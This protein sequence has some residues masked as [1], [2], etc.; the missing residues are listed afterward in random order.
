MLYYQNS[1]RGINNN[2]ILRQV[3]IKEDCSKHIKIYLLETEQLTIKNLTE[4]A[5]ID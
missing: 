3:G 4:H 5:F 1:A 2:P